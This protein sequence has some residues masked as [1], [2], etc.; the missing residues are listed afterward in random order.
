MKRQRLSSWKR[1]MMSWY[2]NNRDNISFN[3]NITISDTDIVK[4]QM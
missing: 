3:T 2:R 1:G 4:S